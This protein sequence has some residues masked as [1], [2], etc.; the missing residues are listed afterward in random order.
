MTL[1]VKMEIFILL[2]KEKM[3]N[4]QLKK[5]PKKKKAD[6]DNDSPLA[7]Q[8]IA[9]L[10]GHQLQFNSVTGNMEFFDTENQRFADLTD[11]DANRLWV[12]C[13]R[14]LQRDFSP[15]VFDRILNAD[16]FPVVD[17]FADYFAHL[18]GWDGADHIGALAATVHTTA[19]V[20]LFDNSF[21]HWLV[22]MAAGWLG[23]GSC[24]QII[25]TLIGAQGLYKSTFF[26]L[27][28]PPELS[29][30]FLA[31]SNSS[32]LSKDDKIAAAS[33]GLIDF[34]ELDSL[35]EAD[36]NSIKALVSIETISERAT[37]AR[38][39]ENRRRIASFCA[40]GNNKQFLTDLTGNRRWH[41]FEV[42]AIDCPYDRPICYDQLYAQVLHMIDCG[43]NY[44]F[45]KQED[46][47]MESYKSSFSEPCCEE[48]LLLRY[49]RKPVG[50]EA[51]TQFLSVTEI[52]TI[53]SLGQRSSLSNRRM[54]QSLQ[55]LGF[56]PA[57]VHNKRGY[58]VVKLTTDE[59]NEQTN[60][61][62][63]TAISGEQ[64]EIF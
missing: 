22:G 43:Y 17:P 23:R 8:V 42:S 47:A 53:C 51:F 38:N 30:Y 35:R 9:F 2:S 54:S 11:R 45:S 57:R 39:R 40:T 10:Q 32:Y 64:E 1:L 62:T 31:K 20:G 56:R 37:Y 28:L 48:E 14:E 52:A 21:R 58:L 5:A 49:F 15:M 6:S 59:I 41:P 61:M 34:E 63:R 50:G 4:F 7:E 12:D 36:L 19:P 3:S 18:P 16:L 46:L 13:T 27:L 25:L 33:Y 44:W 26:R 55:R 24:N 60:K 29:R